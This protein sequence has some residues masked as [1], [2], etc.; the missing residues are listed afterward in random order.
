LPSGATLLEL[1][2]THSLGMLARGLLGLRGL[3]HVHFHDWEL[4]DRRRALALHTL[5]HAL[6]LRRTPL[7]VEELAQRAADAPRAT[8]DS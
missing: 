5:L 2:A 7:T 3:V 8:I 1:P 6:R 4:V